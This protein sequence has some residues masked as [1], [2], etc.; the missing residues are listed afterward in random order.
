VTSFV[1]GA[2]VVNLHFSLVDHQRDVGAWVL[3]IKLLSFIRGG[4]FWNLHTERLII[5]VT[6]LVVISVVIIVT[7]RA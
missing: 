7:K 5:R 1:E 2:V 6:A 3:V 4:C